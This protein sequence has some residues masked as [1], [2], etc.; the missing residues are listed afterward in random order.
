MSPG[1]M[2][3]NSRVIGRVQMSIAVTW[4]GSASSVVTMRWSKVRI[5]QLRS[6]AFL[7]TAERLAFITTLLISRTIASKRL[8]STDTRKG[9]TRRFISAVAL[10]SG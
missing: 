7:I 4:I 2:S 1:L 6:L 10:A 9:S 3:S 8:L 5:V